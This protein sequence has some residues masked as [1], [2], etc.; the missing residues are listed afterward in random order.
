MKQITKAHIPHS[1]RSDKVLVDHLKDFF[2]VPYEEASI[3]ICVGDR[4]EI[5][6]VAVKAFLENKY[7]I[8]YY[9]G[10]TMDYLAGFDDYL[11]HCITIMSSEQWVENKRCARVVKKLCKLINK[12]SNIKI[13]GSN[14]L[15]DVE[16]DYSKV[17]EEPYNLVLYNSC[18]KIKEIFIGPNPDQSYANLPQEQLLGLIKKCNKFLSNSSAIVYE[19]P[20]LIKKNQIIHLGKRNRGRKL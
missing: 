20:F 11:R 3:V 6:E 5:H 1:N 9:A 13:V 17:P 14:H 4:P 2:N 19:A 7:L 18:T 12:K 8:H 15:L 16:L 10:V